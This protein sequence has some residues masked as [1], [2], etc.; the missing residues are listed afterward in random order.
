MWQVVWRLRMSAIALNGGNHNSLPLG[1]DNHKQLV[2]LLKTVRF[3]KN[4]ECRASYSFAR[5]GL[6]QD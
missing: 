2:L 6:H 1:L 5:S 3:F 4:Y